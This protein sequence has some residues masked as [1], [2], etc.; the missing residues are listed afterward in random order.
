M[1][2]LKQATIYDTSSKFHLQKMDVLLDK[3]KI[4]KVRSRIR[5]EQRMKLVSSDNLCVSPGWLDI[6]TF[7][8]EP[9]LEYRE[10]L[11]SLRMAAA[12]GGF[13]K[14]AAFPTTLPTIDTKGQLNFLIN[15]TNGH[16]VEFLPIA[17]LTKERKGREIA[18]LVDLHHQGAVAFSDGTSHNLSHDQ[19][20]RALLYLKSF[21]GLAIYSANNEKNI[22]LNEGPISVQVGLDGSPEFIETQNIKSAIAQSSYSDA[23]LLIHNLSVSTTLRDRDQQNISYSIPCMNLIFEDKDIID[24]DIN[25]K[26]D[27]PLRDSTH[28][29]QLCRSVNNGQVN[30]ITS[31]HSPLSPEEKDQPYGLSKPGASTIDLAF[32]ALN[33]FCSEIKLE[34]LVYCLSEGPHNVLDL[35]YSSIKEGEKACLTLFDPDYEFFSDKSHIKSKSKNSPFLGKSMRGLVLG[36]INGNKQQFNSNL[37]RPV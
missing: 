17:A 4:L 16:I 5:K 29:K 18:E 1:L 19:L 8:G 14:I 37:K 12:N 3:G 33:T 26:V 9:G 35:P 10:D 36:I 22:Q 27:P 20:L 23:R 2:L 25:L 15:L 32:S 28:R 6:G 7:N 21:K 11:E 34:R 30:I 13:C 31:N 24:F